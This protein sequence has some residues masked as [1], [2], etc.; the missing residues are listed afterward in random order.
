MPME[1]NFDFSE[2]EK[3]VL[4][5]GQNSILAHRESNIKK[6][7]EYMNEITDKVAP[8]L[9]GEISEEDMNHMSG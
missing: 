2:L 6:A 9:L 7:Q 5:E 8:H 3:E 1:T 4:F